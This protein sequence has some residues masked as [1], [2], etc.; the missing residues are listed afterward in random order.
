VQ[1]HLARKSLIPVLEDLT[2][3]DDKLYVVYQKDKY[4]PARV[5]IFIDYLTARVNALLSD[6]T[7]GSV[8]QA[9]ILPPERRPLHQEQSYY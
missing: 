7:H 6:T 3:S 9:N 1:A 5:R 4:Q 8:Q 2:L